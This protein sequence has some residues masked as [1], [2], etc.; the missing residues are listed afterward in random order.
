LRQQPKAS[1]DDIVLM[2]DAYGSFNYDDIPVGMKL[3]TEGDIWFQLGP[4][5]LL[6]RYYAMRTKATEDLA[7]RMGKAA[8]AEALKQTVFFGAGKR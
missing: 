6:K 7:Q 4:E 1:G 5:V 8:Q 3:Q 2:M